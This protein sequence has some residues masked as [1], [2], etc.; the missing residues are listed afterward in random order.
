MARTLNR[1]HR[2]RRRSR[3]G[4]GEPR[5][6]PPLFTDLVEY[7]GPGFAGFAA[8]RLLTRIATQQV[9]K[10]KLSLG[11]H[12]GVGI[13]VG[14]FLAAWFL[15]NRVKFLSRWHTPIVVGAAIAAGQS[16]LQLYFPKLGWMVSDATQ[17]ELD[18]AA[19]QA[20][21]LPHPDLQVIDDDPNEYTYN[22][23]FDA[24]RMSKIAPAQE[25][26]QGKNDMSD[27]AIEDAVGQ[28]GNLG[29]F[30]N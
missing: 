13:S 11:K 30:N 25:H 26:M 3:E 14:A 15:G 9:A 2:Q 4:G 23:S 29:V 8:T 17:P 18:A 12:A 7:I 20:D 10:R 28:S 21:Q 1:R 19:L 6:N 16:I 22:D 24:G 5:R 27:L